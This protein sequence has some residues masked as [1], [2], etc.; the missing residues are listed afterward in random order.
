MTL[1][2]GLIGY[3]LFGR[4][5][6]RCLAATAG[7]EL[8]AIGAAS[9][10][11]RA[12]AAADHGCAAV[13]ADWRELVAAPDLDAIDIV[14]P[15]H[16]HEEMAVAALEA[17]KHVL[18]EKPLATTIAGCGRIEAAA[19]ASGR[20]VAVGHELRFSRQWG[21]VK[22]L[23]DHGEIG[24]PN[25]LNLSLFR[26]PYRPGSNGW[27]H[28][29]ARVGSW[30]LE[31]P[32]HFYDLV[33]WYLEALGPPVSVVAH[34]AGEAGI[35][36]SFTSI[37]G[38]A[39]G[40]FAVVGQSVAGFGHH[41]LLEVVG[42]T[43]ALRT[44]WSAADARD[45]APF[46]DLQVKDRAGSAYAIPIPRSGELVELEA[47]IQAVVKGFAAGRTPLPP[48]IGTAAVRLCLEAERSLREGRSI[49][50]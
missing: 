41:L 23:V 50:L 14:V 39:D 45:P 21:T 38:F 26:H 46:F 47:L 5:H 32:V 35:P 49:A 11:S 43:G 20:L 15:N 31:E 8:R 44:T 4:H 1:R 25:Y 3:G 48:A 22:R 13:L 30:I 40:A 33:L 2:F 9:P 18:V 12:A 16:L 34:G 7:A 36:A 10:S 19:R 29:P 28:D 37:I 17:G 6:A 27:R 24:R 42:D